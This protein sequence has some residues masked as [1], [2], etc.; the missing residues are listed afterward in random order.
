MKD[1]QHVAVIGAGAVGSFYGAKLAKKGY[2]VEFQSKYLEN[3]KT[4]YVKSIW[5]DFTIPIRAYAS[6]KDMKPA[7][8]II[9]STKVLPTETIAELVTPIIK[10]KSRIL[11]LQNGINQEEKFDDFI[12][13]NKYFRKKQPIILGGL[14][15]TCINRISQNEVHHLDYG[16]IK[17]GS[18]KK[19]DQKYAK[20]ITEIFLSSG[21]ETEFTSDLRKSR[22]EKLLWNIAFNTLSVMGNSA[23]T[24]LIVNSQHGE[25]LSTFLMN[26][27]I[28]I[29]EYEK[30]SPGKK[31]VKEMIE[32]TKKMN[33]YK[34][35]MLIDYELQRPMEIEAIVGEPLQLAKKY[36]ILVPY[37]TFTYHLLKFLDEQNRK[38][39]V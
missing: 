19:E 36:K 33:P 2:S 4:L 27:I 22:W 14:A 10:D 32:R 18:L 3:T 11:F 34:T 38:N 9:I 13:K 7:D 6:T 15:F 35:S 12:K 20:E 1:L 30:K 17:I 26:E 37:L 16:K 25:K 39:N 31:M 29:A 21:I 23:T 8:L 24:E 5:G 28:K